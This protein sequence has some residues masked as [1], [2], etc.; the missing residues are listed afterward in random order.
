MD[1]QIV[2]HIQDTMAATSHLRLPVHRADEWSQLPGPITPE[3]GPF[4]AGHRQ[5][6]IN[7][8]NRRSPAGDGPIRRDRACLVRDAGRNAWPTRLVQMISD[9]A[10]TVIARRGD[11]R[12][13]GR[14]GQPP[15]RTDGAARTIVPRCQP[16]TGGAA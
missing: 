10:K 3:T 4:R 12:C 16:G 15:D 13:G 14:A 2:K 8:K 5:V 1:T 11:G 7:R 6:P 9:V